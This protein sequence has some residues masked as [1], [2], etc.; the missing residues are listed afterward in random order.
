MFHSH[1]PG[2]LKM[3]ATHPPSRTTL[4]AGTLVQIYIELSHESTFAKVDPT[5][6]NK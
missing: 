6:C 3:Q 4:L 2:I 1:V 5:L